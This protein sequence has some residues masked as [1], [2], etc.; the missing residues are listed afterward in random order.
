MALK[1]SDIITNARRLL[2]DTDSGGIRWVD[3]ELIG[4]LNEGSAEIGRIHPESSARNTDVALLTGTKQ[5]IPSDG[6]QL[7][8][9]IRNVGPLG[10]PGRVVRIVDRRVM[11]NERP[12]WHFDSPSADVKRYIF[13][14]NDPLTFYVYPPNTGAGKLT[15]VYAAAPERVVELNDPLPIRDIYFAAACNYICYRAWQKQIDDQEAQGKS[16]LFKQ[17]FDQAMGERR[18]IEGEASPNARVR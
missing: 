3:N 18:M 1:V 7:L 12:D 16:I 10:E 15:I 11:D 17:L 9:V 4:W 6:T 2:Q 14:E 5:T 8:D 13:N